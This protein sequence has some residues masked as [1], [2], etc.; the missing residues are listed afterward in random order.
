MCP[1]S[2]LES[3]NKPL[4]ITQCAQQNTAICCASKPHAM[5]SMM[6]GK[7]NF[8]ANNETPLHETIFS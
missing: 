3:H 8:K 5:A 1:K 4:H 7:W 2:T 6:K